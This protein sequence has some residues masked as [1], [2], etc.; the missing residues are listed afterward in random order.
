MHQEHGYLCMSFR[1]QSSRDHGDFISCGCFHI[2]QFSVTPAT[3]F[4]CGSCCRFSGHDGVTLSRC[5]CA[6]GAWF[7]SQRPI[8]RSSGNTSS[9]PM[10]TVVLVPSRTYFIGCDV[11]DWPCVVSLKPIRNLQNVCM[12][13]NVEEFCLKRLK[14]DRCMNVV[15]IPN[16]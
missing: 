9:I 4:L 3:W 12:N 14:I 1:C 13:L 11:S 15:P 7:L 10:S 5:L 8:S 6:S 2:G 16:Q